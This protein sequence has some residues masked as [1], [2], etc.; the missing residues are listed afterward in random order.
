MKKAQKVWYVYH[1]QKLIEVIES[2]SAEGAC[3]WAATMRG[4]P[5]HELVART[6]VWTEKS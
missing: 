3:K 6:T 1:N 2:Y 5:E 4:I